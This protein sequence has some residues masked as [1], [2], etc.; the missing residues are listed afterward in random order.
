MQLSIQ[1]IGKLFVTGLL[2]VSWP[3]TARAISLT[4]LNDFQDGTLQGWNSGSGHANIA[5]GGPGGAGD[6]FL[7]VDGTVRSRLATHNQADEWLGDYG[8]A[9]VTAIVADFMTT[10]TSPLDMRTVLFGPTTVSS[11]FTSSDS[12]PL[13]NDGQWHELVFPVGVDE[14]T[15]VTLGGG[16]ATYE[17]VFADVAQIMF[18]HQ[19]GLPIPGGSIIF[20]VFNIDNIRPIGLP[21]TLP[22]DFNNSMNVGADDLNLVLFNWNTDGGALPETWVNDRPEV[23]KPVGVDQ[24]NA[25]LFNW[26]SEAM[27]GA[28][29]EPTTGCLF[30][31]ASLAGW[32]IA[33]RRE[34]RF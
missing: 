23:G 22:G 28:V 20:A 5:T 2:L 26:G 32:V 15:N 31:T 16:T 1:A 6:R 19:S 8:A 33:R 30:V 11:R 24:L 12:V 34:I 4:T 18:R 13:L 7:E 27:S 17:D 21:A 29:P 3:L 25:V 10:H 9:G 14:L